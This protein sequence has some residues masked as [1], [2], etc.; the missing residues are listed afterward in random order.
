MRQQSIA[1]GR[2]IWRPRPRGT[3]PKT[4]LNEVIMSTQKEESYKPDTTEQQPK[5]PQAGELDEKQLDNVGGGIGGVHGSGPA[6]GPAP[7]G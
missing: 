6:L 4:Q 5:A 2:L 7:G 1:I 3:I